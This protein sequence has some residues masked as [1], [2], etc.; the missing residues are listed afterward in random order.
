MR[1]IG[2]NG[3]G[4]IELAEVDDPVAGPREVVVCVEAVG[5]CGTDMHVLDGEFA[6]TVDPIVP[7]HETSG[8]VHAIGEGVEGFAIGD[9]VSADPA[10]CCGEC[11]YCSV[12]RAN[13]CENWNGAGVAPTDGFDELPRSMGAHYLI[14]GD[15]TMG[16]KMAQ[17]APR[18]GAASVTVVDANPRRLEAARDAGVERAVGSA[19]DGARPAGWDEFI[20]CTGATPAID[21]GLGRHA[22]AAPS[23]S[24]G[25][26]PATRGRA[27]RPSGSP[28]TRSPSSVR[29]RCC[30]PTPARPRCSRPA[31]A[32]KLQVRPYATESVELT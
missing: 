14:Y 13:L 30:T 17:L 32:H 27:P 18:A 8:A 23:S 20:D 9:R 21:D 7:G 31:R 12:G 15:E 4:D 16:V 26:P 1:A 11:S 10:R 29:W 3:Q 5:T 22:S 25:C 28:T 2:S 24:S 19:S 6:P